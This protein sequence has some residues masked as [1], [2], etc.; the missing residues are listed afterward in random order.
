MA[1]SI[2]RGLEGV[3]AD[4]TALARVDGAAGELYYR[5][6]PIEHIAGERSFEETASMLLQGSFPSADELRVFL[7]VW[8]EGGRLPPALKAVLPLAVASGAPVM[9]VLQSLVALSGSR[10]SLVPRARRVTEA[11]GSKKSVVEDLAAQRR[12]LVLLMGRVP[13]LIAAADRL[14]R[15]LEPLEPRAD[16]RPMASFLCMFHGQESPAEDVRAFEVAELLQLEHGFNASTFTARVVGSTL[17]PLDACLSAAIGALHG[18]LHGGADEAAFRMAR[19]EVAG[20]ERAEAFVAGALEQGRKIMGMG[21]RV[22]KAVDPR[23]RILKKMAAE[24]AERKGGD[25]LRIFATLEAV[26]QAMARRMAEAGK[27]IYPN[28]EFYKGAV[29]HALGIPPEYFTAMFVLARVPGWGAHVL[30]LWSDH[31]LYRPKARY[32]GPAP[33]TA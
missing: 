5:Q 9:Q 21:H 14:S 23:A 10:P 24:L 2:S 33:A 12:E 13:A 30:E 26:E 17:A 19:D 3:I 6:H 1:D 25:A 27:A 7:E 20:P 29:F 8:A 16:L 11:D 32:V 15:G 18:H 31:R 28:V 4:E 22:Y